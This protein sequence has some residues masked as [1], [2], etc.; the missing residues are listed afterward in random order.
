MCIWSTL[1]CDWAD[2]SHRQRIG[3][4]ILQQMA[5]KMQPSP[6]S[7]R[8][9]PRRCRRKGAKAAKSSSQRAGNIDRGQIERH[10]LCRV[11]PV[12]AN[13]RFMIRALYDWMF[14][15]AGH[16]N[17]DKALAGISFIESSFFPIPPDVMLIPMVM[18]NRE[19]WWRLALICTLASVAGAVLGYA[20]GALAY[21]WL[22]RP[23]LEFY[24]KQDAFASLAETYNSEWGL[25]AV[26]AGAVTFLP[27][28]LFTIF[29]GTTGLNFLLFIVISIIGR[30]L[31]FFVVAF[32]L[33]KFGEP[34]Q[35]FVEKRLGILF[36]AGLALLI[37]G[38]VVIKVLV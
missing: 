6:P 16:R 29:S 36:F 17:A 37:G 19:K 10:R 30:G 18:A 5:R 32:L 34:I 27:Y 12:P 22:G 11:Y 23:I 4:G 25:L 2:Y 26:F 8:L 14:R 21:E 35:T 1:S 28:K 24:G 38:F 13:D 15:L 33:F 3:N 31:R 9:L 20:I 7:V